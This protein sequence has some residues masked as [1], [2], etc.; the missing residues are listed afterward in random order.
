MRGMKGCRRARGGLVWVETTAVEDGAA[1]LSGGFPVFYG[2]V[3]QLESAMSGSRNEISFRVKHTFTF[4]AQLLH[5]TMFL[6]SPHTSKG[7]DEY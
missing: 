3:S 6:K 2:Y 1:P 5:E 4:H 7:K